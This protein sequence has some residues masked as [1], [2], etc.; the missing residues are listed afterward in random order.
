ML[1]RKEQTG[2]RVVWFGYKYLGNRATNNAAEYEALALGLKAAEQ[3]GV[4]KLEV[5]GDSQL[6]AR[7]LSGHASV[8][9]A[10]IKRRYTDVRDLLESRR[11]FTMTHTFREWNTMADHLANTAMNEKSS[12]SA[13]TEE[14]RNDRIA[15]I[16]QQLQERST[17]DL[18]YQPLPGGASRD[19]ARQAAAR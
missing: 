3:A 7:Q 13:F 1:L 9:N 18:Q 17:R 5:F 16:Q 11:R 14:I 19:E 2:W 15:A 10:D 12:S 6:I 4:E 8:R